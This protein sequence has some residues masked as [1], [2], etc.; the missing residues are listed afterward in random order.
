MPPRRRPAPISAAAL[1]AS[2][3]PPGTPQLP[4][5]KSPVS[6]GN[7]NHS[8]PKLERQ[9][10]ANSSDKQLESSYT[11]NF[12]DESEKIAMAPKNSDNV[13]VTAT[14]D[15]KLERQRKRNEEA[16]PTLN[17][18][19]SVDKRTHQPRPKG[20][21]WKPFD[22]TADSPQPNILSEG[23]V[24]V[25]EVR[26]NTFRPSSR[27]SSLTR[28]MSVLSHRTNETGPSDMNR[29]D[30]VLTENGFVLCKGRKTKKTPGELDAYEDKPE[31]R[32]TTVEATF[33]KREIY[34]VFGNALPGPE[35]IEE[36][37]GL[38]NGQLQF[39]QHPNGDVSAQ[40]WSA[41]RYIWENIGQF[42]NI[43][44]KVEGQLA[45]DR[46]KGQTAYQTLQQ[47]TLA[48]FRTIAKQREATVMGLPF[49]TKD[50]Q[51]AIPE[52][53]V[54]LAAAPTGLKESTPVPT[55][56]Q[57]PITMAELASAQYSIQDARSTSTERT[58]VPPRRPQPQLNVAQRSFSE[59]P[60]F[61]TNYGPR[62]YR[63]EDPFYSGS[64]YQQIYVGYQYPQSHYGHLTR[65]TFTQQYQQTSQRPQGLDYDFHFPSARPTARA[66][67]ENAGK[68]QFYDGNAIPTPSENPQQQS[69]GSQ[70]T[71][72]PRQSYPQY[73]NIAPNVSNQQQ[74]PPRTRVTAN[75]EI[76]APRPKPVTPYDNRT[77]IR[78]QLWKHVETAKER[79]L[80]QANIRTVLYDP[81]QSPASTQK[82]KPDPEKEP[83]KQVTPPEFNQYGTQKGLQLP[84]SFDGSSSRFFPTVL[85]P[86]AEKSSSSGPS[87]PENNLRDSDPDPYP[88][89]T[90]AQ[91]TPWIKT[92]SSSRPTPQT[93]KAPFFPDEPNPRSSIGS[94][95]ASR[96]A[97]ET[98]DE[99]LNK[100]FKNGTTFQRQQE[101]FERMTASRND[102]LSMPQR[103]P[104][105]PTPTGPPSRTQPRQEQ[106]SNTNTNGNTSSSAPVDIS[107]LMVSVAENLA[108]YTQGPAD[109]RRG[110]FTPWGPAPE[111]AIDRSE[112][113]N[114]SFYDADWGTPPA[115]IGRDPR[116]SDTTWQNE[117]APQRYGG[118]YGGGG[119][120]RR[121][122]F[123]GRY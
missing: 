83:E 44:K 110:Y 34:N 60:T 11:Q 71:N 32:Q 20:K 51:A 59:Q 117:Q 103:P 58:V 37:V 5:S 118:G 9:R 98:Y 113:G 104:A 89:N 88:T 96:A 108:S 90:R 119:L 12:T 66:T 72:A 73:Q 122:G 67:Q 63:Q 123:G 35:F 76:A 7:S 26:V 48:Y 41:E 95:T 91:N 55:I 57:Q 111:W 6:G 43:R 81:Y 84:R 85:V 77:A 45:A 50:I 19:I 65:P 97:R 107:R 112:R 94:A 69:Y 31:E 79:S 4:D 10:T 49:G 115:R 99:E 13:P 8:P 61:A 114:D 18:S 100:W 121:F 102:M 25:P 75:T 80:S 64:S 15:S 14:A 38:K 29:Q 47:N 21:Q 101:F 62:A 40:Q 24:P 120:D 70:I 93:F 78:D 52:P 27:G 3:L 74:E 53:R 17:T 28:S 2:R 116:Y 16:D 86:D 46:L 68:P 39:I 54:E 36:T 105:Q 1:P 33:D 23:G 82:P 42:S 56:V 106:S 87:V 22:Y 109:T 30:S 92:S